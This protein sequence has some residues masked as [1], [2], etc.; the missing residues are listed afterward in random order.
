MWTET[1]LEFLALEP[2]ASGLTEQWGYFAL[3][4]IDTDGLL[5]TDDHT[6]FALRAITWSGYPYPFG[7]KIKN[8]FRTYL[9]AFTAVFAFVGV[10]FRKV[11]AQTSCLSTARRWIF[12]FKSGGSRPKSI[13]Q[14]LT[15]TGSQGRSVAEVVQAVGTSVTRVATSGP[16][17][18][19]S[20]V[21]L[22]VSDG[23]E[24]PEEVFLEEKY[25][26]FSKR[27]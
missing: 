5:G 14:P 20:R 18:A 6:C 17:I 7:I 27:A 19:E 10:Y 2:D 21:S 24:K 15:S 26:P 11:H 16:R 25:F 4:L 22:C 9:E 12:S 3:H 8:V 1:R 23:R 13:I